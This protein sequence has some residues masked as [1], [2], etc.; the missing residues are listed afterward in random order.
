MLIPLRN[1]AGGLVLGSAVLLTPVAPAMAAPASAVEAQVG[2]IGL[3]NVSL[4]DGSQV[5]VAVPV[6]VAANIC[7]TSVNVLSLQLLSNNGRTTCTNDQG[8]TFEITQSR[9]RR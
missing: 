8:Q 2:Q 9:Q 4:L 3:V 1:L 7:D 6:Q 5:A